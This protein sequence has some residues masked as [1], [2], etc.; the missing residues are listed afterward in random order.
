M[1]GF[2]PTTLVTQLM[3]VEAQP[4][5]NLKT[6]LTTEN[7]TISTLQS[8]NTQVAALATQAKAL[9]TS[10]GWGN[11]SVSSSSSNVAA[12]ATTG[13]VA[14]TYNFSVDQTA[15][16]HKLAFATSAAGTDTVVSGSSVTLTVNGVAKSISTGTGTLDSLVSALNA[17]GTGVSASKLKLDD[18]SYRLNVTANATGA[19]AAF[20][21][22]NADGS[23]L[24]GGANVT[25]G[26]DAAITIGGDTIHSASNTFTG[27]VPGA[28]FTVSSAA[29]GSTV[30]LTVARDTSTTTAAV[31][32]LV[33]NV[34]TLLAKIDSLTAYDTSTKAAGALS[35][36]A[37]VSAL[38][39]SLLD[40]VYPGDGT[41]LSSIGIQTD[42]DGKLVFDSD[43]FTA[44]YNADPA[45]VQA[46]FTAS[47]TGTTGFADRIQKIAAGA[48]DT[49]TGTLTSTITNHQ[50]TAR[51]LTDD[52]ADWDVRLA[53][54]KTSLT[55]LY[56]NLATTLS[57]L[58]SQ[59]TWLS[60][61]IDSLSSS[62]S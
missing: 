59:S 27:V 38:R 46:K 16:A 22:T 2:D 5:T 50:T 19:A 13:T 44:A 18:G 31:K 41:S 57:N 55:T 3:T 15:Q 32:S 30:D 58:N 53:A 26:R 1:S 52:I 21:L 9:A 37:S 34:N 11:L 20:T 40:A 61:Q 47:T 51:R 35:G 8:L 29:V 4:Q 24:L 56:T 42:R 36:D 43:A 54:K 14:G 6:K 7:S 39:D 48:S 17:T 49:Y 45:A 12:S 33:D 60:S 10:S 25:Q 62:S 28:T 23:D